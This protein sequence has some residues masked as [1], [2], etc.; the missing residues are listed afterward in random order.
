MDSAILRLTRALAHAWFVDRV[1][2]Q[3]KFARIWE[4]S[5][6]LFGARGVAI[7]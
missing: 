4:H 6:T 1:D 3:E 7:G 5:L 2:A